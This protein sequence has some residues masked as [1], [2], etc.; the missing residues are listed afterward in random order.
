MWLPLLWMRSSLASWL[1]TKLVDARNLP[2]P[3]ATLSEG[4]DRTGKAVGGLGLKGFERALL[5]AL[6]AG[7]VPGGKWVMYM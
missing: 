2:P 4:P 7:P 3:H 1:F 5:P 6:P